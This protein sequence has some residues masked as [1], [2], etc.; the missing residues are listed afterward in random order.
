[1]RREVR[2]IEQ[3][4]YFVCPSGQQS[5]QGNSSPVIG[6]VNG[7]SLACWFSGQHFEQGSTSPVIGQMKD[8]A[9]CVF[10]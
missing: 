9:F 2:G 4:P 1:V 10:A 8:R 5:G 7:P 6:Q 3:A